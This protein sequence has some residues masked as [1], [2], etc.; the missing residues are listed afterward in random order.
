MRATDAI[1]RF[2]VVLLL[3]LFYSFTISP[4][5]NSLEA[6]FLSN[7]QVPEVNLF[8]HKVTTLDTKN[9]SLKHWTRNNDPHTKVTTKVETKYFFPR[10]SFVYNTDEESPEDQISG[11][12]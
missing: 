12:E 10:I 8:K 9:I 2:A 5:P 11:F 4:P 7:V 3:L 1:R 6:R